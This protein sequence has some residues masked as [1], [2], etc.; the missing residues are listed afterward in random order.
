MWPTGYSFSL[1]VCACVCACVYVCMRACVRAWVCVCVCVCVLKQ[2]LSIWPR[3]VWN[4]QFSFSASLILGLLMF[5]IMP[6]PSFIH[7]FFLSFFLSFIHSFIPLY[8][9]NILFLC[10]KC[11]YMC[12]HVCVCMCVCVHVHMPKCECQRLAT[13]F[14]LYHSPFYCLCF[15]LFW[16]S[17]SLHSLSCPGIE[18]V[19]QVVFKLTELSL[20]LLPKCWHQRCVLTHLA[21][22]LFLV[23][24][25]WFLVIWDKDFLCSPSYPETHSVDQAGLELR[26]RD[27]PAS[28]FWVLGLKVYIT[29]SGCPSFLWL[30]C[31]FVCLFPRQGFSV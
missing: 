24:W 31:L 5:A 17:V 26:I 27:P 22:K 20:P 16:D 29:T 23:F 6:D 7:S 28:T 21:N 19:D 18:W 13:G 8:Y 3:L 10:A 25:F 14:F 15:A 12:M 4:L 9:P 2:D 30:F 11:G 1:C